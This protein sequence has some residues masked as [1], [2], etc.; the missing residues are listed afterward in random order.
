MIN[1]L[2]RV[3][4]SFKTC[5]HSAFKRCFFGVVS[6]LSIVTNGE[7]T[8]FC[9]CFEYLT[10]ICPIRFTS[11]PSSRKNN[12]CCNC[13]RRRLS[14]AYSSDHK[15]TSVEYS[16]PHFQSSIKCAIFKNTFCFPEFARIFKTFE[17][18]QLE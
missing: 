10:F 4:K 17:M 7:K 1:L 11:Y 8:S 15:L 18:H 6:L 12:Y 14:L 9:M 5:F 2:K 13:V 3:F 16:L